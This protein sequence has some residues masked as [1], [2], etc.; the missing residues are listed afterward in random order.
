M[1]KV[2]II[3]TMVIMTTVTGFVSC[4]VV[5]EKKAE[6]NDVAEHEM[7]AADVESDQSKI[8]AEI[9]YNTFRMD[10]D[11]I[12]LENE[13]K[14][15]Q[16]KTRMLTQR[17]D[18]RARYEKDLDALKMENEKLRKNLNE[19]TYSTNEN[20]QEFKSTVVKDIDRIGKSISDMT[21]RAEN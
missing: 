9:A 18:I 20:W 13:V 1:K 12:L 10:T 3:I 19:F 8:D 6:S 2:G 5:T 4:N 14:M 11:R 21:A 17:A 7:M 16:L 15:I